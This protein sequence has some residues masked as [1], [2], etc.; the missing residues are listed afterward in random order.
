LFLIPPPPPPHVA[1]HKFDKINRWNI[2]SG[3]F[4]NRNRQSCA[5][6]G[7]VSGFS[8]NLSSAQFNILLPVFV[9]L[10]FFQPT[11]QKMKSG[12]ELY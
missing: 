10:F 2:N 6:D 1:H 3:G 4:T 5:V 11:P 7:I 9:V 12:Q 8:D